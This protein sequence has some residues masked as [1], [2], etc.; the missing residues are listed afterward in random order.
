[1]GSARES[2]DGRDGVIQTGG[3]RDEAGG[4]VSDFHGGQGLATGVH[5]RVGGIS[6][7]PESGGLNE[8]QGGRLTQADVAPTGAFAIPRGRRV[9]PMVSY[10]G[11]PRGGISTVS[12]RSRVLPRV[13]LPACRS[14]REEVST[15]RS[16]G[17]LR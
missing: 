14:G 11:V 2:H 17:F 12:T 13:G 6:P 5:G 4:D 15:I 7:G 3:S 1:M 16:W 10:A 8:V 9:E